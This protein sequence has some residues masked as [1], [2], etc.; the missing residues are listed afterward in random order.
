MSPDGD[1]RERLQ[2]DLLA[3]DVV[4]IALSDVTVRFPSASAPLFCLPRLEIAAG[5]HVLLHGPSGH[6]KTTLLHLLSGQFLPDSGSIRVGDTEVTE[7][8]DEARARFR[9]A[10]FGLIFQRWNLVD[11]LTVLENIMLVVPDRVARTREAK[12]RHAEVCL[13]D[14]GLSSLGARRAG[15]VSPGEQQRIAVAKIRA[16]EPAI[17]LA[18]E[19]TSHL[20]DPGA[21]RVFESLLKFSRGRTLVVVSHDPRA[22]IHFHDQDIYDFSVL[23]KG[24][25]HPSHPASGT[26]AE[27]A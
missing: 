3:C 1:G 17:V 5:S 13:R 8:D 15:V 6:G 23:T 27:D 22:R 10:H 11:H 24:D 4:N 9:R 26:S 14:M 21:G 7:L 18:D 16:A 25:W 12:R 20:D 19:P 2:P